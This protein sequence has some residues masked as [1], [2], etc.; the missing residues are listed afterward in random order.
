MSTPPLH[1]GP[2]SALGPRIP[3]GR[4]RPRLLALH[5]PLGAGRPSALARGGRMPDAAAPLCRFRK[6]HD[7]GNPLGGNAL[8]FCAGLPQVA[9]S[10]IDHVLPIAPDIHWRALLDNAAGVRTPPPFRPAERCKMQR[11]GSH[12][13]DPSD[14]SEGTPLGGIENRAERAAAPRRGPGGGAH[15]NRIPTLKNATN[16][17]GTTPAA[18]MTAFFLSPA[19]GFRS[20]RPL[21]AVIL[22]APA[23]QAGPVAPGSF[24]ERPAFDW[25]RRFLSPLAPS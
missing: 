8:H 14:G 23:V 5:R 17:L 9:T 12:G 6:I 21:N 11:A 16:G 13:A 1:T 20:S 4:A 25:R 18:S 7:W 19:A 24:A 2:D 15:R 22:A 3:G 10:S